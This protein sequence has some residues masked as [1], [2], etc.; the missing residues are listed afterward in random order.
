MRSAPRYW[1]WS[2]D[3]APDQIAGLAMPGMRLQRLVNYRRGA[4]D[5]RRFA[6]RKCAT[7]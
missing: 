5:A 4:E 6:A 2:H 3:I 7:R 1:F